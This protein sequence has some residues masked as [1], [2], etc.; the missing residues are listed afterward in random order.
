[1]FSF[2]RKDSE[3]EMDRA[4]SPISG[5]VFQVQEVEALMAAAEDIAFNIRSRIT[6]ASQVLFKN[7]KQEHQF[8]AFADSMRSILNSIISVQE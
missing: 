8:E 2:M 5:V 1:M 7:L 4:A 3:I 6:G